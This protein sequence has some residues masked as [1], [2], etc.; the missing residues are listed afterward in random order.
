MNAI[1]HVERRDTSGTD[2]TAGS[3]FRE[4]QEYADAVRRQQQAYDVSDLAEEIDDEILEM[5]KNGWPQNMG[6]LLVNKMNAT[7]ARRVAAEGWK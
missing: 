1:D 4:Q 6:M 3:S 5:A 2:K 7:I